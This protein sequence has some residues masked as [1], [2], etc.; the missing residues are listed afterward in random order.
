[1]DGIIA[2][3]VEEEGRLT[4]CRA[5]IYDAL[6][7]GFRPPTKETL[8]RLG[9]VEGT[10]ALLDASAPFD[11]NLRDC[12]VTMAQAGHKSDIQALSGT[13]R[14]LFGHTTRGAVPPY[15]TEYGGDTLFL[16]PQEMSDIAGF[17]NAFGLIV[18]P[19]GHERVD[20]ISCECEFLRF[21]C[22]KEAYALVNDEV[23]MMEE[24]RRAERLF[25]KDHLGRFGPAFGRKVL[26]MDPE[27]FYGAL[28]KL[29]AAFIEFECRRSDIPVGP[30]NLQLRPA[31]HKDVP[32]ACGSG[33]DLLQINGSCEPDE[34]GG[35]C[36]R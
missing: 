21:L 30:E 31:L 11:S 10:E 26:R 35:L 4:L 20:H 34:D 8:G 22:Q 12:V 7:L 17:L 28:G 14:T 24:T 3:P 16:Q 36:L 13:F 25:L 5:I 19:S 33:T 6:A 1:M 32:M 18:D 29:C 2:E 27:G 9:S 15:E 23:A